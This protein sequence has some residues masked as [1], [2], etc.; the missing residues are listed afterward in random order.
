[1][2]FQLTE[3]RQMLQDTLRRFFADTQ[4]SPVEERWTKL[5]ELG[6]VGAL[7]TE[8]QGGFG[9]A[10]FDLS[11]VF[12]ELGRAGASLPLL[13]TGVLAGGLIA[14]LGS[15]AQQ[16]L[17]EQAIAG[18]LQLAFAHGEPQSRYDLHRVS[19][20]A[21][22]SGDGF[23]LNGH[24]SVVLNGSRAQ[25]LI[26]S[27]RTSGETSDEAGISLFIVDA[28]NPGVQRRSYE[29]I[30]GAGAAEIVLQ[31]CQVPSSALL[32]DAGAAFAAIEHQVARGCSALCAEALGNMETAKDLTV[33]YLKTR[34]QFGVAI[35]KFQALQHRMA[36]VLIEVEQ[37]RSATI[38]TC[39]NLQQGRDMRELHVSA[40]KN[41]IGRVGRL[42][43]EEAIQ[44]HGGIGMTQEYSLG[45][46]AKRLL[47]I[48]HELGDADH[49]LQRFIA[50][51]R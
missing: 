6:V 21:T 40:A 15:E 4:D 30:D 11:V 34:K 36:D 14:E 49:H 13:Q 46:L 50:F 17:V 31:D 42:V 27:A 41:L 47:M 7:F 29:T 44:L 3:E 39:G 33:E 32:G 35:G 19:S 25:Q 26:V 1:M 45:R 51:N 43:A 24:K 28:D 22:E 10:G 12:E 5:A 23:V 9:G 37:A 8:Q 16:L 48:D 38:N 2:N 18:E 20:T